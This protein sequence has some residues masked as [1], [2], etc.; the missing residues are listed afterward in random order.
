M[1]TKGDSIMGEGDRQL[2]SE[3]TVYQMTQWPIMMRCAKHN[4][5]IDKT[6]IVRTNA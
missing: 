4:L 2:L 1:S 6:N 3:E 5:R